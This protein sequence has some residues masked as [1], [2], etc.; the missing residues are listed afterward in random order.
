M[1]KTIRLLPLGIGAIVAL[2]G[3]ALWA[4][5]PGEVPFA[6]G[7][8]VRATKFEP[9]Q[10]GPQDDQPVAAKPRSHFRLAPRKAG[11]PLYIYANV[12][13]NKN[14]FLAKGIYRF[15]INNKEFNYEPVYLT[16]EFDNYDTGTLYDP[17]GY[18]LVRNTDPRLYCFEQDYRV[19]STKDWKLLNTRPKVQQHE[20]FYD[21]G[22]DYSRNRL[23]TM[24]DQ[25]S[26]IAG[27]RGGFIDLPSCQTEVL[28]GQPHLYPN[29]W[30]YAVAV[31]TD[32]YVYVL[33][34]KGS[35]YRQC[36]STGVM[37]KV[38][39][40]GLGSLGSSPAYID[41]LTHIMYVYLWPSSSNRDKGFEGLWAIDINT[42]EARLVWNSQLMNVS[43]MYMPDRELALPKAPAQA[44]DLKWEPSAP[45]AL[46]GK[47][48]F[49][50]PTTLYDG[51]VASGEL[52]YSIVL[53]CDTITTGKVAHGAKVELPKTFAEK[54][55]HNIRISL[56]NAAGAAPYAAIEPF[57]GLDGPK[58]VSQPRLTYSDGKMN[59]T[60]EKPAK[61]AHGG[62]YAAS[63]LR[64][65]VVRMP[66]NVKVATGLTGTS[67][68]EEIAPGDRPAGYF[69]TVAAYTDGITNPAA[70]HSDTVTVGHIQLPYRSDF[71]DAH[72]QL[73]FKTRNPWAT[74]FIGWKPNKIGMIYYYGR[75]DGDS[76]FFTAPIAMRK[77]KAYRVEYVVSGTKNTY[78]ERFEVKCGH[79]QTPE[80][81]TTQVQDVT[82][83]TSTRED[84]AN[85]PRFY[86]YIVP[87]RDGDMNIGFHE[88]SKQASYYFYVYSIAVD[89]GLDAAAPGYCTDMAFAPANPT[90]PKGTLTFKAPAK[91][92]AGN[93]LSGN[94]TVKVFRDSTLIRTYENIPAGSAQSL[95]DSVETKAT[96]TYRMISYNGKG[97]GAETQFKAFVGLNV[98]GLPTDVVLKETETPGTVKITWKAPVNDK[99]GNP[100]NAAMIRYQ[101]LDM[102]NAVVLDDVEGTEV[103]VK[104]QEPDAAPMWTYLRVKAKTAS[105]IS[106]AVVGNRIF[107][108]KAFD[109]PYYEPINSASDDNLWLRE[110]TGN[111]NW[112]VLQDYQADNIPSQNGDGRYWG[113]NTPSANTQARKLGPKIHI[114]GD[115]P[116]I[117]FWI[118]AKP[119]NQNTCDLLINETGLYADWTSVLQVN[120]SADRP[121]WKRVTFPMSAYKGKDVQIGFHFFTHNY[122]LFL[123]DHITIDDPHAIDLEAGR[124]NI[125]PSFKLDTTYNAEF[126]ICNI[127]TKPSGSYFVDV[128][129][130]G[131]IVETRSC[132]TLEP[133]AM[134]FFSYP[135]PTTPGLTRF[136]RYNA[137]IRLDADADTTNNSSSSVT[138]ELVMP[139]LPRI[140]S[141]TGEADNQ[142]ASL[143][144]QA[145][146]TA[147][148]AEDSTESVETMKAFS[149]G[150]AGSEV[151]GDNMGG[152]I[153]VDRDGKTPKPIVV[154]NK[155]Y[156][157]FPN[158]KKPTGFIV[159]NHADAGVTSSTWKG[160]NSSK[161]LFMSR[162]VENDGM[163]DDWLISPELPGVPFDLTLWC[164]TLLSSN[165]AKECFEIWTSEGSTNPDD[166]TKLYDVVGVPTSWASITLDIPDG[167]KRFAIR[168]HHDG[169]T[170]LS[171]DD[172]TYGVPGNR[173][174]SLQNKGYFVYRNGVKLNSAPITDLRY[175]DATR[176]ARLDNVYAVTTLF[177]KGEALAG[178]EFVAKASSGVGTVGTT[179][180]P[181]VY[182]IGRSIFVDGADGMNVA[183]FSPDGISIAAAKGRDQMRF[184]V[185]A[186]G[187]YIVRIG[188]S[189]FKIAVK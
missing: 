85:R 98:P 162:P 137:R 143:Q 168:V 187:V 184:P 68:S 47:I 38:G 93:S 36:V 99:D 22:W 90:D 44:K 159:W 55:Y 6:H 115:N 158:A 4:Q 182:A 94:V 21:G 58:P 54:Q 33:G 157:S 81:M 45:G 135:Q 64:F 91:D 127:G 83:V 15:N 76:W 14:D 188:N 177:D 155:T 51:T 104:V 118:Y 50:A 82:E 18:Y 189:S 132:P 179:D 185:P 140:F 156:D 125:S 88:V 141:L 48:T 1:K 16:D 114:D 23:Y 5:Q 130:N 146:N 150:M 181:S 59:L 120:L 116:V 123:V 57:I 100:I 75:Y 71:T 40:T 147:V 67:F 17:R 26:I 19:Y 145:P 95:E 144:W 72:E 96:H 8:Q 164:R 37:T 165:G 121:Q 35:L 119:G 24:F 109:Y 2:T 74:S 86:R 163:R 133:G 176:D 139:D 131:A 25:D 31:N 149:I 136:N 171:L 62:Y 110:Q 10:R 124:F 107:I 167:A 148:S 101:I 56:D 166:F 111:V 9:K 87:D 105:G 53:D 29:E 169:P 34:A 89:D 7:D 60:W 46:D 43:G 27:R 117:S 142:V 129:R 12:G 69:Y 134:N 3:A 153:G 97:E 73:S 112:G 175:S 186:Q 161:Q 77:G 92:F 13:D 61:G 42:A 102:K 78:T 173:Y 152:W 128:Y 30:L 70:V 138:S 49:T 11:T 154:S 79:G 103:N 52:T 41:P 113:I 180:G 122:S 32:G 174:A 126:P 151:E 28:R 20:Y 39:D 160:H 108:G 63:T 80:A 106:N 172:I 84:V 178:N 65:D 183:L 66:D 170:F